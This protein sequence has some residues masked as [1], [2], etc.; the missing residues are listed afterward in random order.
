MPSSCSHCGIKPAPY[1]CGVCEDFAFCSYKCSDALAE[2]HHKVCYDKHEHTQALL[3]MLGLPISGGFE[4]IEAYL[5]QADFPDHA[6]EMI[7]ARKTSRR[8]TK[9]KLQRTAKKKVAAKRRSKKKAKRQASKGRQAERQ[10]LRQQHAQEREQLRQQHAQA[11]K[12]AAANTKP[13]DQ[14]RVL[15]K[16]Y[17]KQQQELDAM[18]AKQNVDLATLRSDQT[19]AKGTSTN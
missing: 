19:T 7:G 15:D 17:A 4:A 3:P 2:A 1:V 11:L 14:Q 10:K 16:L 5:I 13:K 8:T 18:R 9:K 6:L 12:D